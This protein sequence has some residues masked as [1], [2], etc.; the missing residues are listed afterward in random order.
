MAG[1]VFETPLWADSRIALEVKPWLLP[2]TTLP[3]TPY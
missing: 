2:Y 3:V 1:L